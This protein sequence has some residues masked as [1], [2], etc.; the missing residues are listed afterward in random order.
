VTRYGR[1]PAL[2][3]KQT[4]SIIGVGLGVGLLIVNW[5][6]GLVYGATVDSGF[7]RHF[8]ALRFGLYCRS[9][10]LY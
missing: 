9:C 8:L 6:R 4:A 2:F 3:S 1:A 10:S 7:L 5:R